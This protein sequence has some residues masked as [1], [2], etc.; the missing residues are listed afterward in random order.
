MIRRIF[1]VKI[2]S[3]NVRG[4][5]Q[6]CWWNWVGQITGHPPS[7]RLAE[8]RCEWGVRTIERRA[9][10]CLSRVFSLARFEKSAICKPS[11]TWCRITPMRCYKRKTQMVESLETGSQRRTLSM[12]RAGFARPTFASKREKRLRASIVL[13]RSTAKP[14][15]PKRAVGICFMCSRHKMPN[16]RKINIDDKVK[17]AEII[18]LHHVEPTG[19]HLML[20]SAERNFLRTCS[21]IVR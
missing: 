8:N 14:G 1:T 3:F 9:S 4:S 6:A 13:P 20:P 12:Y 19:S 11:R 7:G 21:R 5:E 15:Q 10:R 2:A 16:K 17:E 18:Y